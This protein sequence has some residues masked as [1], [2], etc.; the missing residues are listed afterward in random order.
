MPFASRDLVPACMFTVFALT[1]GVSL[2][3]AQG[4]STT[5]RNFGTGG[6]TTTTTTTTSQQTTSTTTTTSATGGTGTGGAATGGAATGGMATGGMATGGAATGGMATGGTGT[7]GGTVTGSCNPFTS[8]PCDIVGGY[9]CDWNGSGFQ[10]FPPS[11][12]EMLCAPCQSNGVYCQPGMTCHQG[13]LACVRFCCTDTDCGT[14][15]VCD[16]SLLGST[17]VGECVVVNID[18]GT[19]SGPACNVPVVQ[20]SGGSCFVP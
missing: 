7:G 18:G 2:A 11:N 3:T 17:G 9:A 8:S 4:C 20:P 16:T 14:G 1:A 12:T 15:N 10:C 13:F 19:P 6:S 5:E